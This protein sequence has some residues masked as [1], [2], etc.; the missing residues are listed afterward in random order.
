MNALEEILADRGGM[1]LNKAIASHLL[2]RLREFNDWGQCTI[3]QLLSR[4]V[5]EDED[6]VYTL[7]NYLDDR[8]KQVNPAVVLAAAKVFIHLTKD[9]PHL[10]AD[11]YDAIRGMLFK[12]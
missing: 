4:Y 2:S 5:P 12:G 1:M 7:L 11:I 9:L 6:E 3:L 8:M 10:H